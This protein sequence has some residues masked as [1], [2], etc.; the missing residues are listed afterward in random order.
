M[1]QEVMQLD[2]SRGIETVTSEICTIKKQTQ[3][4]VLQSAIEIGRRLKEAKALV[5]YGQW[6]EYLKNEVD[7]SQSTANNM[8]KLADEYGAEQF[9]IFGAISDSQTLGNLPYTKALKL[10]S[11]PLE[12]REDFV[13]ENDVESL[14][15]RELDK[16]LKE[17]DEARRQLQDTEGKL[18]TIQRE[19]AVS[20]EAQSELQRKLSKAQ[21]DV[22][23][24]DNE[25][26]QNERA[27]KEKIEV[28]KADLEKKREAEKKAK[29][30]LKALKEN[31]EVPQ[32]VLDRMKSEAEQAARDSAKS[33]AEKA[34]KEAEE[35]K[36]SAEQ[37]LK[38]AEKQVELTAQRLEA[39]EKQL[40]AASPEVT[41]FKLYFERVQED[42]N[43]MQGALLKVQGN[44]PEVAEKL[45]SAVKAVLEGWK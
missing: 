10:L 41:E 32:E 38:D 20:R 34:I 17:R 44:N 39:L 2:F 18:D 9:T 45:R 5:P 13:K 3:L 25:A 22:R 31:P 42:W 12:E 29:E 27:L 7:F 33:E 6:G 24:A 28:L 15:T 40:S 30:K 19:L 11:I 14:S 26:V 8:M 37:A 4:I 1:S 21:E 36:L 35:K 16:L 23:A 43:R